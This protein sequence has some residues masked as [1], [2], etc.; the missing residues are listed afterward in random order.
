MF[1]NFQ[2]E[3][4]EDGVMN[5]K[6]FP[7][8]RVAGALRRRLFREHLGLLDLDMNQTGINIDD[9]CAEQFYIN[10]WKNTSKRNTDIYEEVI[11][12][13]LSIILY[14]KKRSMKYIVSINNL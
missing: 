13:F 4:F 1:F 9:P 11:L 5:S 8:G 2:D 10:V 14:L 7:V 12:A 3:N 6:P